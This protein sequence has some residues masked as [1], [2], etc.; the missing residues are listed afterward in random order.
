MVHRPR[1]ILADDHA[2]F[3]EGLAF[4]L[5]PEMELVAAV[6]N[7]KELLAA[8]Q[9]LQPDLIVADVTMPELGGLDALRT[10]RNE[11]IEARVII[12][13]V[14]AE[15]TLATEAVRAGAMGYVVKH[16]AG[17]EL[18]Q[19]LRS[20]VAGR[21]YLSPIVSGEVVRRLAQGERAPGDALT[22]RQREVLR[23]LAEGRRAKEIAA[24]LGLSV[25]TVETHKYEI[26]RLLEIDNTVDLVKFAIRHGIV[27]P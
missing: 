8:A 2:M 10:L 1:V 17:D 3:R 5:P 6:S 7:G 12:L 19:A 23:L 20:A 9:R 11:G 4:L 27:T 14:H 21:T 15:P 18:Q 13:T 16:A 25:R 22:P 24:E 26:M